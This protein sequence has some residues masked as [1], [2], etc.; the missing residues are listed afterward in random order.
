M[1]TKFRT[2]LMVL[3]ATTLWAGC[4]GGTYKGIGPTVIA[5]PNASPGKLANGHVFPP[6]VNGPGAHPGLFPKGTSFQGDLG[7]VEVENVTDTDAFFTFIVWDFADGVNQIDVA[8]S[9]PTWIERHAKQTL[10]VGLEVDPCKTYQPDVYK[11]LPKAERYTMSDVGNYLYAS[12]GGPLQP[13]EHCRK[14]NPPPPPPPPPPTCTVGCEP[15]PPPPQCTASGTLTE[16]GSPILAQGSPDYPNATPTLDFFIPAGFPVTLT[17]VTSDDHGPNKGPE[18]KQLEEIV[19]ILKASAGHVYQGYV[20][21]THD[22]PDLD[23]AND[24]AVSEFTFTPDVAITNVQIQHAGPLSLEP[25]N[26]VRLV[27]LS[28]R[29]A[30]GAQAQRVRR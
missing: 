6:V 7:R 20:G 2:L 24:T 23:G 13:K 11:G 8:H 21:P 1:T 10:T 15:P 29:C 14:D 25:T 16:F 27:S 4:D 5:D 3:L 19:N 17:M 28:V 12:P 26:S 22:V 9:A 18:T 30:D